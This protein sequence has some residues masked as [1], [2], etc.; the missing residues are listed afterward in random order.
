MSPDVVTVDPSAT[1]TGL[2]AF[3]AHEAVFAT[4]FPNARADLIT[5]VE[6]GDTG[7]VSWGRH[8]WLPG[9][10]LGARKHAAADPDGR[11][12]VFEAL[13]LGR[14]RSQK[15]LQS[16]RALG[17]PLGIGAGLGRLGGGDAGERVPRLR[18]SAAAEQRRGLETQTR[19]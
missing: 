19:L 11:R 5:A 13:S 1:L 3:V 16:P 15:G 2:E 12:A 10:A 6:S 14:R 9:P 4:A 8:A 18:S 7:R 17:S